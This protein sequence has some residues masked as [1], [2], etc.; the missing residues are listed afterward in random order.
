MPLEKSINVTLEGIQDDISPRRNIEKRKRHLIPRAIRRQ[1]SCE[2]Q[3]ATAQV[4][5]GIDD[6][7]TDGKR[8]QRDLNYIPL[9]W[10]ADGLRIQGLI[11]C[12]VK[13]SAFEL[14]S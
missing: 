13:A 9:Q 1:S 11:Q 3:G 2:D 5:P 7:H 6:A 10:L 4:H 12:I 14:D 8:L